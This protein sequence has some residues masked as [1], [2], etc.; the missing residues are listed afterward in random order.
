MVSLVHETVRLETPQ[1]G[2]CHIEIIYYKGTN[3]NTQVTEGTSVI[4]LPYWGGTARSYSTV[5]SQIAEH[6]PD[7]T[8][9][10][11]SYPGTGKSSREIPP[12]DVEGI[13]RRTPI[14]NFAL[15]VGSLLLK[16]VTSG[17]LIDRK[18]GIVLVGHSMGAKIATTVLASNT[19]FLIKAMI[20]LAPAPPGPMGLDTD[21][22]TARAHAY[23][24]LE[25]ARYAIK[26]KL[27]LVNASE[28]VL[29][30]LVKDAVS[31]STEA[32]AHWMQYGIDEDITP[33]L[34]AAS[35]N[36]KKTKIRILAGT[37]DEVETV[38]QI[39]LIT[40]PAF[41]RN[42]FADVEMVKVH[43]CGHI[44]PVE[45]RGVAE[46]TRILDEVLE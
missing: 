15:M 23:D 41:T 38:Q 12:F 20:L 46:V 26:E 8:T 17:P 31:M 11:M 22:R 16:I 44:V 33:R 21:E 10:A 7:L 24:S 32:K 36:T 4:F 42:G 30:E 3:T 13:A 1:A 45:D 19:N 35:V 29:S 5:Q 27:T 37:L 39:K 6:R 43:D 25:I 28:V 34:A 40:I 9:T 14:N 2:P 18:G